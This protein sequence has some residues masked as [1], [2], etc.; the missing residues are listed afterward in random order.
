MMLIEVD[1]SVWLWLAGWG[2]KGSLSKLGSSG[3]QLWMRRSISS[4]K[5]TEAQIAMPQSC[6]ALGRICGRVRPYLGGLGVH[7]CV[8]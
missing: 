6:G 5:V 7:L 1:S 4:Q 3:L 8:C 2:S